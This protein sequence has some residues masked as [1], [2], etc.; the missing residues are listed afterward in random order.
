MSAIRQT[1]TLERDTLQRG[2]NRGKKRGKIEG[3]RGFECSR[4]TWTSLKTHLHA[5]WA[6]SQD[7]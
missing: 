7:I 3:C 2:K 4:Q 6:A 5:G 1:M